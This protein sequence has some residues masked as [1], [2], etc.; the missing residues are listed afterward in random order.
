MRKILSS[1]IALLALTNIANAQITLTS[2]ETATTLVNKIVSTSGTLGVTVTNP[3]L[4]CDSVSNGT[5]SGNSLLGVND[6]IV[7]SSGRVASDTIAFAWGLN[8]HFL[9]GA[10]YTTDSNYSDLDLNNLLAST[11]INTSRD[12][13]VL[14]FD[15][16]PVGN[17]LEFEYVFGSEEYPEFVCSPFNDVFGFFISGPGF[18]NA[19][20]IALLPNSTTSVCINNVNDG[21]NTACNTNNSA[22]YITN[23]DSNIVLDGFTTPLIA[24]ANV[25]PGSTYHLKL[26]VGDVSDQV[27]DSYVILQANSLKSGN[28]TSTSLNQLNAKNGLIVS[29][30]IFDN[31]INLE[32]IDG[33]VWDIFILDIH[34]KVLYSQELK[35]ISN[36]I[37]ASSLNSGL[38]L[39]QANQKNTS[40]R[41]QQKLMKL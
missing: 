5:I 3:V 39:I 10:S 18:A 37:D 36:S 6:G 26:A 31:K 25:T 22:F 41:L 1:F 2:N 4:K 15:I 32:N 8:N 38:Y 19:T 27:L 28:N 16:Q 9:N 35:S 11:A 12:A 21:T 13:C 40:K 14:E 23:T 24:T 17:F 30:S 7:L 34:G 29:P 20:N 33:G